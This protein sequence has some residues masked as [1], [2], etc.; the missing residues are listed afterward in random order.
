MQL[1]RPIIFFDLETTGTNTA[2]DRILQIG[3]VKIKVDGQREEKN[4][5]LNP[6]IPIPAGATAVHGISDED[7]KDAP[8]FR[9]V[10]KSFAQW[11]SGCDLAGYNSDNF[12]VPML[13][14]E[15]AR[16]GIDFPEAGTRF[17]DILKIERN[18]NSHRLE[19]TYQR[20]TGQSLDGAHDALS[21]IRATVTIFQK[22]LEQNPSLPTAIPDLEEVCRGDNGRV[23]F[24]GK[25]YEKDGLVYWS[26]GKHKDQLVSETQEYAKWVLG[27]DFPHE[28]KKQL[29]RLLGM[30]TN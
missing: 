5:L 14:E 4:V 28:T 17:L 26:F 10:A 22:Q 27:S 18:V 1:T 25:L 12:D 16:V 2:Q 29:R 24:A 13:V 7:V 6:G 19:E 21:D 23:D 8:Y 15:F 20:Y 11:L 9:Q 3:A 30:A